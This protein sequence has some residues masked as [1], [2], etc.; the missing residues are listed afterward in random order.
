MAVQ[1]RNK[2]LEQDPIERGKNFKEVSLG[3]TAEVALNEAMRCLQCK[4][5]PCISGCP[6]GINIP[7]FIKK[8][9]EKDFGGAA[10]VISESNLLPAIC[11]RVCPQET[12][13]EEKCVLNKVGSPVAIG[14]LERFVGDYKIAQGEKAKAITKNGGKVA[15]IG[16]GPAGLTCAADCAKAGFEVTIFEAFHMPGGVLTYGIPEFR[17]PKSIV[18]NEIQGLIDLGV[19]IEK[20]VVVGR[21]VMLDELREEYDAVFIGTGAG[22]PVFLNIP[23]EN[24]AGV[25]SANEYLTRINLMGARLDGSETPVQK[26]KNV[27][28]VGAGN[29]AM[30]S[31]RTA[32]RMGADKVTIVYRRSRSEMPARLEEIHHAEEEGIEMML[33]TNPVAVLGETKV[34]RIKCQKMELGA[35]DSKGRPRPIPIQGSEFEMP[36]DQVI[37][38]IGTS[39]NPLLSKVSPDLKMDRGIVITDE[40]G[41]TSLPNVYAGGDAATGAAT[42]ILAMSAGRRA[43]KTICETL[44]CSRC[45]MDQ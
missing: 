27:V 31:A 6:V 39:P 5:A 33:L 2:P 14:A 13:C 3:F 24:L 17:L 30:D 40:F 1:K 21:T 32:L 18:K 43:A 25:Y 36:C 29:V 9:K 4:T 26:G 41:L 15:I 44:F 42:V 22:L 10:S 20:N 19:V 38:A 35:P 45:K 23:G 12:Q 7:G 11:G 28:V 34:E 37:M 16:S 8:M